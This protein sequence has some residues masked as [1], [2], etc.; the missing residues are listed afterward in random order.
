METLPLLFL[1]IALGAHET[2]QRGGKGSDP[3]PRAAALG[4][5]GNLHPRELE[6]PLDHVGVLEHDP[7]LGGELETAR[8]AR[9]QRNTELALELGDL[10][11][12]RRLRQREVAGGVRERTPVRDRAKREHPPRVHNPSLST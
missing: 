8:T 6:S 4:G 12:D 1:L 10:V 11:G 5:S 3:Q 2:R 7:A 9:Q